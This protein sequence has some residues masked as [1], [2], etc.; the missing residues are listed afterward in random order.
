M[1]PF[2]TIILV[3]DDSKVACDTTQ[4]FLAEFGFKNTITA[5]DG[6]EAHAATGVSTGEHRRECRGHPA[7]RQTKSRDPRQAA[8]KHLQPV[9]WRA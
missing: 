9:D 5:G 3:V 8:E 2:E 1:F 6:E 7:R 4:G